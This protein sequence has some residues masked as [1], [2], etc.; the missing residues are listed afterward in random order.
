[1]RWRWLDGL[2]NAL[3][4]LGA[5]AQARQRFARALA[6]RERAHGE[7]DPSVVRSLNDIA[8]VL[9]AQHDYAAAAPALRPR[10]SYRRAAISGRS[11]WIA[12]AAANRQSCQA[13][14]R[15]Q[16]SSR[17]TNMWQRFRKP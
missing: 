14:L 11:F 3:A 6:I 9:V 10:R 8:L 1:M 13:E 17:W 5:Y 7:D 16:E 4:K 12:D 15:V 2:G